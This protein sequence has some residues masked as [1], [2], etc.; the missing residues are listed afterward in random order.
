[1]T[2]P[3]IPGQPHRSRFRRPRWWRRRSRPSH[4]TLLTPAGPPSLAGRAQEHYTRAIQA[5]RD[6]DW[7]RYGEELTR[8]GEVLER[9]QEGQ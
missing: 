5:Q 2:C 7:A 1:M 4:R 6:G 3:R 9:M 8:L